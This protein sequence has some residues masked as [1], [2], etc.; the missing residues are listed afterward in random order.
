MSRKINCFNG[1]KNYLT[2]LV[3]KTKNKE[4][5]M[6]WSTGTT[7]NTT[8][9][10]GTPAETDQPVA[11]GSFNNTL[12]CA[13]RD[14]D[15]HLYLSTSSDGTSWTRG[16][17]IKAQWDPQGNGHL[18]LIT[19]TSKY[20]PALVE[21]NGKLVLAWNEQTN[22]DRIWYSA[23][24][25]PANNWLQ[26]NVICAPITAGDTSNQK[27]SMTVVNDVLYMMWDG[28]T[29]NNIYISKTDSV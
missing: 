6:S 1:F 4:E 25:D 17:L 10:G 27:V 26:G 15:G 23:S 21:F 8:S 9:Q 12:Y 14:N 2:Q 19:P 7:I 22:N 11:T 16:N 18:E 5:Y 3:E 29:N 24:S 28:S 20:G 13:W